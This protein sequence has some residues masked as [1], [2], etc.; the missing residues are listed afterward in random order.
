[1]NAEKVREIEERIAELKARW[2]AHSV[3]PSMWQE[4]EDLEE[5]LKKAMN[6]QQHFSKEK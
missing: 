1:M 6:E 2:P 5:E 4:L 3:K